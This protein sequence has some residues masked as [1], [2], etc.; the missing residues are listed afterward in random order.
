MPT[1]QQSRWAMTL[2]VFWCATA[3]VLLVVGRLLGRSLTVAEVL[4]LT[5]CTAAGFAAFAWALASG[6]PEQTTVE[7][8]AVVDR[9]SSSEFR[10][11]A[12]V[13]DVPVIASIR[14]TEPGV[15]E[16]RITLANSAKPG[17]P[18]EQAFRVA[19]GGEATG[20]VGAVGHRHELRWCGRGETITIGGLV[21]K[22]PM[23]YVSDGPTGDDEGSCIDLSLGFTQAAAQRADAL[24]SYPTYGAMS[25]FQ[26][27]NYLR[28]LSRGRVDFLSD[29]GY[30]LMFFHG[31]ERRLLL[32][33]KDTGPIV[34]EVI[35][36][37]ETYPVSE[38]LNRTLTRFLV[39]SLAQLRRREPRR[40]LV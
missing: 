11:S 4:S 27:F 18:S 30:E 1:A 19:G 2:V 10:P 36:L 26:R 34:A 25:P 35:R 15:G 3:L 21:L 38:S 9:S 13:D 24:T 6:R 17:A 16:S 22:S 8:V 40:H 32:E 12:S 37:L 28:W 14:S 5:G 33:R 29:P 23:V 39:F 7:G 20:Y 31:L